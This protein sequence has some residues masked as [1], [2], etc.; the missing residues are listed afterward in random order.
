MLFSLYFLAKKEKSCYNN[1]NPWRICGC[2]STE[3]TENTYFTLRTFERS[4]MGAIMKKESFF[5]AKNVTALAILL[6]L[7][8]V[9]QVFASGI[10]T[11]GVSLNF[12]LIPIVIGAIVLGWRAGALLG[13]ANGVVVLIQVILG[14]V[15]L[16]GIMWTY[17]PIVTTLICLVKTTVAGGIAGFLFEIIRRKNGYLAV[18][19]ASG[20]VPVINTA[21]FILGCLTMWN[22][23]AIAAARLAEGANVVKFI[24]IILVG[25]NF[26][27]EFILNL[28]V[29]PALHTVYGVVEKRFKRKRR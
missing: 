10:P 7:V 9:L 14:I 21:L 20:C 19:V 29:A 22:T 24:F 6:A 17:S 8:I 28:L 18:F 26:L 4:S 13:F 12:S 11:F 15:P 27:V 5:S 2:S 25:A 3:R 23:M 16:Y 1:K